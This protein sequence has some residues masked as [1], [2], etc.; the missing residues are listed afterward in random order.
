MLSA[1]P[2]G[3][4][5]ALPGPLSPVTESP[6]T[7]I[8]RY[9]YLPPSPVTVISRYRY[10]PVIFCPLSPVTVIFPLPLSPVIFSPL[11]PRYRYPRYRYRPLPLSPLPLSPVIYSTP[12][13]DFFNV[14][15]LVRHEVFWPAGRP[16]AWRWLVGLAA[17]WLAAWLAACPTGLLAGCWLRDPL[18]SW[19]AS[20][21]SRRLI[22][23]L[24]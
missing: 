17:R 1:P 12:A 22:C 9:R 20:R 2:P 24:A 21:L 13:P 11:S 5:P 18:L 15:L 6:V 4:R 8:S 19:P 23:P 3:W 7:V 16:A 10:R 14:N